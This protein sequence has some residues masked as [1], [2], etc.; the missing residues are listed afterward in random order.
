MASYDDVSEL[1]TT[2]EFYVNTTHNA[3]WNHKIEILEWGEGEGETQIIVNAEAV[4]EH[5]NRTVF[6]AP[7]IGEVT[8]ALSDIADAIVS[9]L[10][11]TEKHGGRRPVWQVYSEPNW[12][13]KD[14]DETDDEHN[15]STIQYCIFNDNQEE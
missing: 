4:D 6:N 11:T 15:V 13:D 7:V 9:L 8:D 1:I 2:V 5:G 14:G 3:K 10:N 12:W